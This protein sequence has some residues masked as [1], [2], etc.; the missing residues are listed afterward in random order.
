VSE[1]RQLEGLRVLLVEDSPTQAVELEEMLEA[2]GLAAEIAGSGDEGVRLFHAN[3]YDLVLSDIVM[4]GMD[5]Y[6][7]CRALRS[8]EKGHQIPIF[9]LSNL[10][11]PL[12][13][14]RGLECGAS[15]YI[16]KPCDPDYLLNRIRY[17]LDNVQARAAADPAAGI[18]LVFMDCRFTIASPP[19]QILDF[20]VSSFEDVVFAR[21]REA[22][23]LRTE[24]EKNVQLQ[25]LAAL[26]NQL[27]GMAAHDLRNPLSIVRTFAEFLL[28]EF[29]DTGAP[30]Q[31]V[32][33]AEKIRSSTNFMLHLIND[34][35]DMA[36]VSS[37]VMRLKL[38]EQHLGALV[39]TNCNL[40]RYL[41]QQKSIGLTCSVEEPLPT[42]RID[43]LKIEQ[44]LNNLISNAI[45]FSHPGT[46]L[47]VSVRRDGHWVLLSV[48]D[49]GL[50]I[51]R[52][53]LAK[54]FEPFQKTSVRSTAGEKSTGL[55]LAICRR[56]VEDHGGKITVESEETKGSTFHVRLPVGT[57][58]PAS[59]EDQTSPV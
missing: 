25:R 4:P 48:K 29:S 26:N 54:V 41:A 18:P 45:K 55:G 17:V 57:D 3:S 35:L 13:V 15:T 58:S 43:T 49:Q 44:V 22:E 6:A 7:V 31:Q 36:K 19:P 20:L 16:T 2:R 39:Q 50:G 1:S 46:N 11:D 37:G 8:S 56:I 21:R 9:L 42:V 24:K 27:L 33:F 38:E 5:G 10:G 12:D 51:P 59:R 23:H 47:T 30:S 28:R 40:N 32:E 34:I 52:S 53:E 14:V